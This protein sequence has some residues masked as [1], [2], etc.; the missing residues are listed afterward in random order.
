MML[1][2]R[3]LLATMSILSLVNRMDCSSSRQSAQVDTPAT[4]S[5]IRYKLM[6]LSQHMQDVDSDI[7]QF[8]IDVQT[9][10]MALEARG[11][12]TSD[13]LVNLFCGCKSASDE[14]FRKY[15]CDCEDD[16]ND[17]TLIDL[18]PEKLM[19]LAVNQYRTLVDD[20]TWNQQSA[21]QKQIVALNAQ[22]Q[23][24]IGEKN[25]NKPTS[26]S[27]E[28]RPKPTG[29]GSDKKGAKDRKYLIGSIRH[30]LVMNLSLSPSKERSFI[31]ASI[32]NYGASILRISVARPKVALMEAPTK[33]Q[34]ATRILLRFNFN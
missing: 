17:G 1:G 20:N 29:N 23:K 14:T 15:I 21:Q 16:Y 2:L 22:L 9:Y 34:K 6:N 19:S 12:T 18:S 13:L 11:N 24:F 10:V 26:V 8:N 5:E 3:L 28:S 32:M 30:H 27:K 33:L 31:G 25:K 4:V 7:K